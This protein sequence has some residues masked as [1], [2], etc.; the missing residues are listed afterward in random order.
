MWFLQQL[1]PESVAQNIVGGLVLTGV[2]DVSTV[3]R[4]LHQLVEA[5]EVLRT[6]FSVDDEGPYVV[7]GVAAPIDMPTFDL[8]GLDDLDQ[9]VRAHLI[10]NAATPFNLA[11]GPLWRA[12]LLR[13]GPARHVLALAVHHV[14]TDGWSWSVLAADFLAAWEHNPVPSV[15]GARYVDYAEWE[16]CRDG[17]PGLARQLEHW[18]E[19]LVDPPPPLR[20][21]VGHCGAAGLSAAAHCC[22]IP[23]PA[24]FPE[25]LNRFCAA[26][27]TTPFAVFLAGY[28]VLIARLTD[29]DEVLI[30]APVAN[31]NRLEL[32]SVVGCFLNTIALRLEVDG[33]TTF[34]RFLEAV[35][36]TLLDALA[37]AEVP[38]DRVVSA[39]D[40]A[41]GDIRSSLTGS[42]LVVQNTPA[43]S[44]R[45]AGRQVQVIELP[46]AQTHY[47]LKLEIFTQQPTMP[48]RLV[49]RV[50]LF[51]VD[52][53]HSTAAQYAGLLSR[54]IADPDLA[55]SRYSLV[56]DRSLAP[57]TFEEIR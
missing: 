24:G 57:T 11:T 28:A 50:D 2:I 25:A 46:S 31:R 47:D 1:E 43:W 38:F 54:V 16:R 37:N 13:L 48:A 6:T 40:D 8:T 26:R 14:V 21:S 44:A 36:A 3:R 51:S 22:D 41:R 20:F 35:D 49:H 12:R 27:K 56:D 29:Q 19:V 55:V 42:L 52:R 30:A 39:L 10:D 32:E 45:S 4:C 15:A 9:A 5:H 23:W 34:A 18:R 53:G 17:D 33:A 7:V